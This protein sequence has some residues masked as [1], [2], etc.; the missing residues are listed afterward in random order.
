MPLRDFFAN[1]IEI[2]RRPEALVES[3]RGGTGHCSALDEI[4]AI[5]HAHLNF[6]LWLSSKVRT[7]FS[8]TTRYLVALIGSLI[9]TFS[10]RE[11]ELLAPAAERELSP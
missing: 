10:L 3:Q 4:P 2:V 7:F 1:R 6:P 8:A 5:D 11:K 9:L